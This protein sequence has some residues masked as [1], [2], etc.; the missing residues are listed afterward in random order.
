VMV[1]AGLPRIFALDFLAHG[2]NVVRG[3]RF[4]QNAEMVNGVLTW[5]EMDSRVV[6]TWWD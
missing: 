3:S 1:V 6:Q 4:V 2:T 5:E